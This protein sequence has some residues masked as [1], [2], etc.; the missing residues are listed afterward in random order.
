[1]ANSVEARYPFLDEDV[2]RYM[3]RV[4][5]EWKLKGLFRDKHVLRKSA[6]G[7]LPAKVANQPKK[8]F[9]APFG[10]TVLLPNAPFVEQLLSEESVAK[11]GYFC[12]KQ[13][14]LE[15]QRL[16]T[17]RRSPMRTFDEMSFVGIFATQLWHHTFIDNSLCELPG[18]QPVTPP[19]T[20]VESVPKPVIAS[21]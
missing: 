16:K 5:P 4:P 15:L 7:L 6:A 19:S 14:Q 11:A 2:V 12:P 9:R 17:K 18:Y 13:V 21:Y 3:S 1:M 10:D 8:M 20:H